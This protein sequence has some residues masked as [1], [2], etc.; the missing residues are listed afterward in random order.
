MR[1]TLDKY[2]IVLVLFIQ[3]LETEPT[4]KSLHIVSKI[5]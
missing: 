4:F 5:H 3:I 1:Q 2:S